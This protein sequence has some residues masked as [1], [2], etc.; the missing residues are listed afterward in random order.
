MIDIIFSP[1]F[2]P[3]KNKKSM[4]SDIEIARSCKM[5]RIEEIASSVGINSESIEQYLN[6]AVFF[7]VRKFY[8]LRCLFGTLYAV[9]YTHLTLPTTPYV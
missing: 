5:K 8:M 7:L 2:V 9:S 6:S 4:K 1:I 3:T